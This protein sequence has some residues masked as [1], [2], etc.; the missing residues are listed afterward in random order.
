M[1]RKDNSIAV[2][3]H[4][5]ENTV[6]NDAIYI[7]KKTSQNIPILVWKVYI[8][9]V[10]VSMFHQVFSYNQKTNIKNFSLL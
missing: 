10:I 4:F 2:E 6:L 3:D 8:Y 1:V 7:Y 5:P 9:K